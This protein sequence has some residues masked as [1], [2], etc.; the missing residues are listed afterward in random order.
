MQLGQLTK[1]PPLLPEQ[2]SSSYISYWMPMQPD[3]DITSGYCWFDY[4]KNVCRIDGIFNPWS[5][6]KMGNRLW[7]SEIMH[8]NTDESFKSKVAYTRDDMKSTSEFSAQ[9]LTDEIDPCHEL[10][11]TQ[12]VLITCNAQYMGIETVLGHQAEKWCFQRPDNKGPAT[13]YFIKETNH[14]V[15]MITGDPNICASVRDFPNF[16][17]F[18]IDKEIFKPELLNQ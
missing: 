18:K 3:D 13:Y 8:P 16:N 1:T 12:D 7:M 2:W 11:L 9:V 6:I 4:T 14:L 15:R 5:E 10:I 17:T